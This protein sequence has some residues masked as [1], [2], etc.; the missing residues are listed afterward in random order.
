MEWNGVRGGTVGD[1]VDDDV[2][3]AMSRDTNLQSTKVPGSAIDLGAAIWSAHLA[4]ESTEIDAD[5]G[6][7]GRGCSRVQSWRRGS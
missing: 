3:A 6:H 1:L 5:D 4:V 2:Y 7:G